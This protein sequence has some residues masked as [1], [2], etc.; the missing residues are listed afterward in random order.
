MS[1]LQSPGT[2]VSKH[3]LSP[4]VCTWPRKWHWKMKEL[5]NSPFCPLLHDGLKWIFKMGLSE[6]V[7]CCM[8]PDYPVLQEG[9]RLEGRG[10]PCTAHG[11][12][13]GRARLLGESPPLGERCARFSCLET[14]QERLLYAGWNFTSLFKM[15]FNRKLRFLYNDGFH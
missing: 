7:F 10:E 9:L 14:D 5:E 8:K 12:A 2:V 1:I 3:H 11:Q 15:L 13:L 4:Q 6:A